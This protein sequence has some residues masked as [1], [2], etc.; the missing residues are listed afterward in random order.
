MVAVEGNRVDGSADIARWAHDL[1]RPVFAMP[2]PITSAASAGLHTLIR[3]GHARLITDIAHVIDDR[4]T[5]LG[6]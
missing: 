1:A 3:D 6:I 2:G 5:S 4:R